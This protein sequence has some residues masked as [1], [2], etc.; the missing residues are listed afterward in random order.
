MDFDPDTLQSTT[1]ALPLLD[2]IRQIEDA[3][4]LPQ[5]P[6][7]FQDDATDDTLGVEAVGPVLD[8]I[9]EVNLQY[10][11]G[12]DGARNDVHRALL[13]I[14]HDHPHLVRPRIAKGRSAGTPYLFA[15]LH[16]EVVRELV[17]QDTWDGETRKPWA[18]RAIYKVWPDFAVEAFISKSVSTVKAD[19][20]HNA[21]GAQ[22]QDITWAVLDSG[23][24]AQHPHFALWNNL[25][26][27]EP[28]QHRDFTVAED[29]FDH[30]DGSMPPLS[31]AP[32][33]AALIDELGHGTHVAGI[34]AGAYARTKKRP[35][36][37]TYRVRDERGDTASSTDTS[38]ERISG[39]APQTRL[40][41]LKVLDHRGK[42]KTS[43]IIA[44]LEYVRRLNSYGRMLRVHGVN[45]SVGYGFDAEW[46]ACGQSPLCEEVD[47]LVKSGVVVVVAAGNTGYG[48]QNSQS[49]RG[50]VRAGLD[51][52]INDPGNA[53]EAITVGSTHRD[54]PHTY[55]VS[56]F[57]SKG[58]TGD[59]R[60]KPDLLAPG[61]RIL[62]CAASDEP[63]PHRGAARYRED[64]GTSMA[65]PHV[66]GVI[67]SFLSVRRE[68]IGQ[69]QRV[70]EIFLSTATDLGR[71]PYFQGKGLVD[72]M[73]AIQSV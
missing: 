21:F 36:E 70:K 29:D 4:S 51:V 57:S 33:E 14:A 25:E 66:S 62:S 32:S 31:T 7:A 34:I 68:F 63:G 15:E 55:G 64:S 28:L 13:D 46:F 67:A 10:H 12:R 18:E 38:L 72:A 30:A 37:A 35:I 52:S 16:G 47:R 61:E 56:Y 71:A 3:A 73:R 19:A 24:D 40:L 9:I 23:I 8:V 48:Y 59:G 39:M 45:L 6:R 53:Q 41:S 58:P 20:V 49:S 2:K 22:G 27:T 1:I 54:M 5:E 65:A 50:T 69:P 11:K 44:A 42:G 43:N 60:M 17:R 26:T